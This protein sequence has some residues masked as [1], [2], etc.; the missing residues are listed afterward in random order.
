[1]GRGGESGNGEMDWR[2]TIYE[3]ECIWRLDG[4][5]EM[6]GAVRLDIIV[7]VWLVPPHPGPLPK[8]EG[9]LFADFRDVPEESGSETTCK[10]QKIQKQET[11]FF[12][13]GNWYVVRRR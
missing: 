2:F 12:R 4:V 3:V 10:N 8:G 7:I 1:M 6:L 9:E 13:E 5:G 11:E